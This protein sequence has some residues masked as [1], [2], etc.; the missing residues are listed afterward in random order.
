M[1]TSDYFQDTSTKVP[2][3]RPLEA[4][5]MVDFLSR[6][7][8][9]REIAANACEDTFGNMDTLIIT[10]RSIVLERALTKNMLSP[11]KT[12]DTAR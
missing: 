2:D 11:R 12:E 10:G 3:K 4:W 5:W 9:G 8:S 1:L 6:I 7:F